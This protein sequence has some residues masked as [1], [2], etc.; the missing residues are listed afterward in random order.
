[1]AIGGF[2]NGYYYSLLR[3]KAAS[4]VVIH[5]NIKLLCRQG[6]LPGTCFLS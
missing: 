2:S 1:M 6:Q 3:H 5:L 4:C